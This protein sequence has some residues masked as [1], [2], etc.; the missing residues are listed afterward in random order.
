M[1]VT[2]PRLATADGLFLWVMHR[3]AEVFEDH[4]VLKGGMAL[5]LFECPRA[6]TDIDYVLVPFRSKKD[7]RTR[8]VEVLEEI[9]GADV[10]VA[11]HSRMLRAGVRVDEAAIQ[12]EVNVEAECPSMPVPTSGFALAQGQPSRIVRVMALDDTLAHKLAAWNER[13]LLRDLYDVYFLAGRLGVTP[14]LAVLD[15]RL[16]RIE[17]RLPRMRKRQRMTRTELAAELRSAADALTESALDDELAPILPS[18]EL[19][20]LIARLRAVIVRVAEMLEGS[21]KQGG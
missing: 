6:T 17:S 11:M 15:A 4:A 18:D 21:G 9:E 20:A 3:F 13:R 2:L 19:V 12:V 14:D 10:E 1:T 8:I 7:V 16:S 5:R